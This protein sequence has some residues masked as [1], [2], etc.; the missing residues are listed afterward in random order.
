MTR[1]PP[2]YVGKLGESEGRTMS[3][4]TPDR[5]PVELLAEEFAARLRRGEHPSITEYVE[6]Y[7]QHAGEIREL[8]PALALVEKFKP[9]RDEL[10]LA[11]AAS[12]PAARD[13]LPAQLGDYRILRYLGEGGMGVVYEAVRESLKSHVAL[14]AMH[15]QYRNRPNYLRRFH[16]EARSAAGL[17]HTNIVSVFDY[18]EHDGVCYY[19]MQYIAGQSLDKVLDDIRQFRHE[20]A[21]MPT[22][23][24][25]TLKCPQESA[26]EHDDFAGLENVECGPR[27][28]RQTVTMGILTGRFATPGA[29]ENLGAQATVP[30]SKIKVASVTG[31]AA[32]GP[33][34]GRFA[35]ELRQ[36]PG[37]Q[38]STEG[39]TERSA[40]DHDPERMPAS[41]PGSSL[42]DKTDLKYYREVAR[43]G[44]QV[45]EA[46]AYAHQRGVLHRDIKPSN[47]ILDPLGS[48]WIT[49]FGLAK[50]EEGDDLSQSQDLAGTLRYMAP[51]RFRGVSARLGD[52]Y[53]LGA[54]LYELLTLRPAFEGK[55]QL[56]LIHRIENDPPVPPRQ[57]DRKIPIDLETIV[58]KALAKDPS[59]R[60]L[61][62]LEFA[63]E[64]RRFVEDRPIRSR[65]IP[66]YKQFWRWCKRNPKLAAANVA[67]ATLTTVLAVVSTIAAFIYYNDNLRIRRA[68]NK[69]LEQ[70]SDALRVQ[71]RA[72]RF[73]RQIGQRFDGLD[74]LAQAA[75]IAR[76]LKLPRERL[77]TLRD[78]A[79]ACLAL[80]D[81]R[82]AGRAI[83]APAGVIGRVFDSTMTRYAL[84][85]RDGT[86]LV[87]R[88]ADDAEVDRF[89]AQGDRD[90]WVFGFSPDGR[91]LATTQPPVGIL[92]V[93]DIER[94][95]MALD[96][97]GYW[98][99]RFSPESRRVAVEH[100]RKTLVYDLATSQ[101]TRSWGGAA[102]GG[103]P[104][105]RPDGAQIAV[106]HSDQNNQTCRI[107]DAD[108]GRLVRSIPLPSTGKG[109]AWSPDGTTVATPRDDSRIYVWDAATGVRK[110]TLEGSTNV[111][112]IAAFH[113]A[114]N[115]LL[116]N[117]WE[118]KLRFWDPVLGRP[119]LSVTGG[120]ASP[121]LSQDGRIVLW[122]EDKLT[123]YQVDPALEYRTL[124]HAS[125][126]PI[127]YGHASIR[128]DGRILAVGTDGGV[129]IWDLARGTELGSVGTGY[130][131]DC[132]FEESG[133]LLAG[134][135]A[136]V[137]RWPVQVDRDR[138]VVQL[139][140]PRR[141][142]LRPS[143]CD[144]TEDR[145]GR[146]IAVADHSRVDLLTP[147]GELTIEPVDDVRGAAVSPDGAWLA[148][149]SHAL[150]G[151]R[152]WQ[153]SDGTE[154]YRLPI[155]RGA[156]VRFSP[157]GRW[158]MTGASPCC[159]WVVGTWQRARQVGG[160]GLC[161]SA[162]S[163]VLAVQDASKVI[164]LVETA[165]GRTLARLESPDLC[166][167]WDA[168]FSPDGSRLVV[169]TNEPRGAA[170]IWDL[171]AIRKRLTEM[172]LD[173]DAPA[174]SEADP[175]AAT[176]PLLSRVQVHRLEVWF[177]EGGALALQG[178]WDE[179]AAAYARGFDEQAPADAPRWFEQALLRL[180]V[181][182]AKGYRVSSLHML[183]VV[184]SSDK[185]EWLEFA[186]H[187][188][189]LAPDSPAERTEALL[190]AQRRARAP[191]PAAWSDHILGMALYRAR[192]FREAE[193]LL[194]ASLDRDP[195]W[196][197]QVLDWLVLAMAQERLG[198]PDEAR[199][200][201]D[202]AESWVAPRLSGRPGG[203]DR[204]VP[205]NWHWRAGMLLHLLLREARALVHEGQPELPAD[206]FPKP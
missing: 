72:G 186:A 123:T 202:R 133:D 80:P 9:A 55:D 42:T 65:P 14:K 174:Y 45:A 101:V 107:L 175:A 118:E 78:E 146:I 125:S 29:F 87:R 145:Q 177:S 170:H 127:Q 75:A 136:G 31:E 167:A 68:E 76:E 35:S 25:I 144:I 89:H 149:S 51:E 163:R 46:L 179:A 58:L 110:A 47:L 117:G 116:S 195:G 141:L 201:L 27:S 182:D 43:L 176:A 18:G 32:L 187:T 34:T 183:E 38:G 3:Q 88:V 109:C 94:H 22:G 64:L 178:R 1:D 181:G 138:G 71:A 165:T 121:E 20:K 100:E 24:T 126:V 61:S 190:L 62:A 115:L 108:T 53:A 114:G 152:V 180:A 112:I 196:T 164:R 33:A 155:E 130:A 85:L 137:W 153:T 172:G 60:F 50:F 171:R 188:C 96:A 56:E 74:A 147:H 10:D 203:A 104:V 92:T 4:S 97:P 129:V 95:V 192:R 63:A 8:F 69:T 23:E 83:P 128:H 156:T 48:I 73:S 200:W 93:R 131:R 204:A 135:D 166:T 157:D 37:S 40:A 15:P 206:L 102:P 67:A 120:S 5:N 59:H 205:E 21:G 91:Y 122:Y 151:V 6:R 54:T 148:T 140:P 28:L 98:W 161:F 143:R 198:R 132:F 154:R 16:V 66:Y 150:G 106:F 19:A 158:L 52:L 169:T 86:I 111:G 26:G 159:L 105:F 160:T 99:A 162:D 39:P 90:L 185:L 134:G 36:A 191:L 193:A 30:P 41:D 13:Q 168:T 82:R 139:G 11:S 142:A 103:A 57:L 2:G 194:R 184:R 79:I 44:A 189:A 113:P 12:L 197:W 70:L 17:H 199:R 173:W 77:D 7:P 124:A 49:D 119:W 84:R 81:L